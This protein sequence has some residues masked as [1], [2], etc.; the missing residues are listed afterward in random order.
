MSLNG[1]WVGPTV[2]CAYLTL[3]YILLIARVD[4]HKLVEQ[5][6][7]RKE[8]EKRIKED[9]ARAHAESQN[10]DDNFRGQNTLN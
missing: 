9:L 3:C 7:A 6:R 2:A 5:I 1:L 8:E 4:W 10:T